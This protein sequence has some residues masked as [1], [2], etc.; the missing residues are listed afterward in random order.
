MRAQT[1]RCG[2]HDCVR[3]LLAFEPRR[4]TTA[5]I[6]RDDRCCIGRCEPHVSRSGRIDPLK[7]R[8][9][10]INATARRATVNLLGKDHCSGA[11]SPASQA[12]DCQVVDIETGGGAELNSSLEQPIWAI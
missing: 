7:K 10:V 1:A 9:T 5:T 12:A 6:P 11:R 8:E 4:S 2:G 3:A